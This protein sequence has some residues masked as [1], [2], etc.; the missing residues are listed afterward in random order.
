MKFKKLLLVLVLVVAV[1]LVA[2]NVLA[3]TA[4]T[5]GVKAITGLN[6][7]INSMSIG[8]IKSAI[9]IKGLKLENPSGFPDKYMVDMP[10]AYVHYS[11]PAFFKKKVHLKEIRLDLKECMVVKDANG[12]VNLDALKSVQNS[13]AKPAQKKEEPKKAAKAPEIQIDV[14]SL[15]LGKVVFKDYTTKGEPKVQ[16]FPINIEERYTNITNPTAIG[17]IIVSKVLMNTT[18]GKLTGIDLDAVQDQLGADLKNAMAGAGEA[19]KKAADEASKQ[20]K[21]ATEGISKTASGISSQAKGATEGA[22]KAGKEAAG[23]VGDAAKNT[24]D[25]FKKVLPFGGN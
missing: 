22:T 20:L 14:L 18:I 3:K 24:V 9:G 5:G 11:L 12:R 6:L 21:S 16:E 4:V 19:A 10:E 2:K 23:A 13:K 17:A 25:S 7:H 15:K 8:I 1:L